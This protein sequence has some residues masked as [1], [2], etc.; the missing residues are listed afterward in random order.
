MRAPLGVI[1]NVRDTGAY[2]SLELTIHCVALAFP[3]VIKQSAEVWKRARRQHVL[4]QLYGVLGDVA[5]TR[6]G[7][8]FQGNLR[9]LNAITRTA[10]AML[11]IRLR[12]TALPMDCM[13]SKNADEKTS[14]GVMRITNLS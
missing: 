4:R 6:G 12:P 14:V 8:S 10:A 7:N 11:T 1:H 2:L 9:L 3:Y 13:M 5:Q